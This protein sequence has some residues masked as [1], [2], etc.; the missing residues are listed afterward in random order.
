MALG[1]VWLCCSVALAYWP[2]C[3]SLPSGIERGFLTRTQELVLPLRSLLSMR[4][5]ALAPTDPEH[6]GR[7]LVELS[8]VHEGSPIFQMRKLQGS[9]AE[10]ISNRG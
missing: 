9:R 6:M 7:W 8:H 1:L 2:F 10:T 3:H 4:D 5:A